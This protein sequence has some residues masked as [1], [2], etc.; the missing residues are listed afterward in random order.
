[1]GDPAVCICE[2]LSYTGSIMFCVC[3]AESSGASEIF[4][5]EGIFVSGK[6]LV[7]SVFDSFSGDRHFWSMVFLDLLG[8]AWLSSDQSVQ[9]DPDQHH[10]CGIVGA[11][12]SVCG[13]FE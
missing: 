5:L 8:A 12:G 3:C 2:L 13:T 9:F 10:H 11:V 4:F 6:D 1:M 7:F